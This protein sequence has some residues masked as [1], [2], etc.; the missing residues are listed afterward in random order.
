VTW[1]FARLIY[2]RRARFWLA[3]VSFAA[4]MLMM[5]SVMR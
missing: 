4:G 1:E 5:W 3:V 2:E